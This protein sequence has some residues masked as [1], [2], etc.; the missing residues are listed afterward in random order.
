MHKQLSLPALPEDDF[1]QKTSER[2]DVLPLT[3]KLLRGG[4]FILLFL[5]G[6]NF[7]CD[8]YLGGPHV[9]RAVCLLLMLRI[10]TY[11]KRGQ[12]DSQAQTRNLKKI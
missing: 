11:T 2:L 10:K 1:K 6:V 8:G 3:R 9:F 4:C 5:P 7:A 12:F